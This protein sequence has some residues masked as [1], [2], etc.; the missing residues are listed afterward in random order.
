MLKKRKVVALVFCIVIAFGVFT[1]C[2]GGSNSIEGR[3]Q[4][5]RD[6]WEFFSDGTFVLTT[7][8]GDFVGDWTSNNDRVVIS[9]LRNR[10]TI[11]SSIEWINGSHSFT[12][13]RNTLTIEF[14]PTHQREFTRAN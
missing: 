12:V 3:W 8:R 7:S 6:Y 2:G 13:T 10:G 14:S 11:G 4:N 9:G 5:N 1:A